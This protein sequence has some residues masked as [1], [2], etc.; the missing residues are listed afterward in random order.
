MNDVL[1]QFNVEVKKQ[2]KQFE[3]TF[4]KNQRVHKVLFVANNLGKLPPNTATIRYTIDGTTYEE[5]LSTDTKENTYLE[6]IIAY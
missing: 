1:F 5:T 6:F 4:P 2:S 3:V